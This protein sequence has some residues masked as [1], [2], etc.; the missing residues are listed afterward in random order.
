MIK[1]KKNRWQI[2]QGVL[3]NRSVFIHLFVPLFSK[4]LLNAG[5]MPDTGYV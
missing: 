2:K 1:K 5:C 4:H 3:E